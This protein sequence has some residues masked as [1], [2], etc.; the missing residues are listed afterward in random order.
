MLG[1]LIIPRRPANDSRHDPR[2]VQFIARR[3]IC[4]PHY[5]RH[6]VQGRGQP[7]R[8]DGKLSPISPIRLSLSWNSNLP[9][10]PIRD[11]KSI[12][13]LQQPRSTCWQLSISAPELLSRNE[14]A[15]PPRFLRASNT[16]TSTPAPASSHAQE[17]PAIPPPMT[18]TLRDGYLSLNLDISIA[19]ATIDT[20]LALDSDIRFAKTS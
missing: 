15:L 9:I 19:F 12:A 6:Q 20:F 11:R 5:R 3:Q 18:A 10:E 14:Q 2:K 17:S 7:R 13:S 8:L 1:G 4:G 16:T